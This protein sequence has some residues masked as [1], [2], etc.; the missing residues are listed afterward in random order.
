MRLRTST[1]AR[2]P[3]ES[4]YNGTD[5]LQFIFASAHVGLAMGELCM[6]YFTVILDAPSGDMA[7]RNLRGCAHVD[8]STLE[9]VTPSPRTNDAC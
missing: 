7:E 8:R 2:S 6:C 1:F 9:R 4:P 5:T 3:S